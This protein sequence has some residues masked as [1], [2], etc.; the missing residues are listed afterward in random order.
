MAAHCGLEAHRDAM[1]RGDPINTT[2]Q[3]AVLHTLLRRPAGLAPAGRSA[4]NCRTAGR[5][6]C[7]LQTAMLDFAERVRADDRITDIVNIG[8]GGSDLGPAMAV[9]ALEAYRAPGKRLHFVSNV[10]GHEL[11]A[12]LRGLRAESTVFLVASKTFTTAETMTN[13]H[14]AMAWFAQQGGQ[15]VARHFIGLTTNVE[16]AR[17]L[18]ITTCLGFWDW[19]GGRYSLWSAIGLPLA[20]AIG[21]ARFPRVSGRGPCHGRALSHRATGKPT[22]R[23]A[24]AA[25]RLVPQFPWFLQPLRGALPRR[26]APLAGLSAA[27]GDGE[28]RQA[29]GPQRRAAL[30]RHAPVLWG[31]PG[32]N[33]Q[34]AFFQ[35]LHQGTDVLPLEIV[36]VRQAPPLA[37]APGKASGQRAG[38]G[39]GLD[40]GPR[41]REPPPRFSGQ[42]AQQFSAARR[43]DAPHPGCADGAAG[44]PGLCQWEPL[45]HQ[46][47]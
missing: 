36:A 39:P 5:G 45:G 35:M 34:H 26:P 40:G 24:W 32:T 20:I 21:K 31:E 7:T 4:G 44:A 10:D 23:C 15:D 2:E 43:P 13:A 17:A 47:L 16:A 22:C 14:S 42:P 29:C 30:R 18:G 19:V 3:R 6:A 41:Q 8:I 9:R 1:L 27:A 11:H 12:V 25:G 46:Q 33:G 37:G 28:Q 38:A